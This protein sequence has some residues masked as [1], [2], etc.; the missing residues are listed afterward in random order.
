MF[1]KLNQDDKW[2]LS[3][4]KCVDDGLFMLG[5]QCDSDH[6]SRSLIIDLYDSNYTTYNV[7]SQNELKDIINYKK[8][9]LPTGPDLLKLF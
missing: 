1:K 6:S 7:F 2:Y 8:K 3:A 9:S 4:G 5:L